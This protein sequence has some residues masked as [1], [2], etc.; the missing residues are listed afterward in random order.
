MV[1]KPIF[2]GEGCWIVFLQAYDEMTL[3]GQD[4]ISKK[5]LTKEYDAS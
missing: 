1:N 2:I 4:H 5:Y 3:R